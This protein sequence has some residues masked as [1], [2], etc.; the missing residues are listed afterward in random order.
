MLNP[1]FT[2]MLRLTDATVFDGLPEALTATAPET[3]VRLN[4]GKAP[5]ADIASLCGAPD[6]ADGTVPWSSGSGFYLCRRPNFTLL[7]AL[8]QGLLYVQDASSMCVSH[9]IAALAA[10]LGGGA[11]RLLDACAA[12]GGKTL[13]AADALPAG[14]L[15]VANEYDFRRAEIL[16]EN[17]IK[18]GLPS[19]V[20]SRGDTARFRRLPEAFDIV[21]VDAPCSGEGMMRKDATAR[22]Q[23]SPALVRECAARQDEI[24]GN[25]W[26][27]LRPGGYLVYSTCTFNAVENEQLISR[28]AADNGAESID[29]GL[30]EFPGVLPALKDYP[31]IMAARFLP[32]RVRGEG[33]F[34]SVIRKPGVWSPHPAALPVSGAR[35]K[36]KDRRQSAPQPDLRIFEPQLRGEPAVFEMAGDSVRALPARHAAFIHTLEKELQTIHAGT[37]LATLKGRD[38]IPSHTLAMSRDLAPGA[39]QTVELSLADALT[40]LRREAVTLPASAP[41]GYVLLTHAGH[42]LGFAKNLGSRANNLYPAPWRIRNL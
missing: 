16:R 30:S 2:E 3:S 33:I 9:I 40:F 1:E 22:S 13:C 36:K 14:S 7:P 17:V 26:E 4:H 5:G 34:V 35:A 20:V 15:V 11:L 42:P 24:L 28:F 39:F 12:P 23:W 37:E 41:R 8:H 32:S 25:I 21:C 18:W 10:Q 29:T 19:A 31:G 27:A 6:I 38:T